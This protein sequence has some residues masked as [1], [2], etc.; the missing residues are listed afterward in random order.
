MVL[1]S[2]KTEHNKKMDAIMKKQ[3][4]ETTVKVEKEGKN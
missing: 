1:D 3:K 4:I 2:Y